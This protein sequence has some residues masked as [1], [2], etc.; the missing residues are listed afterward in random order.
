MHTVA[1]K[2]VLQ[3]YVAL[4]LS[5]IRAGADHNAKTHHNILITNDDSCR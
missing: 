3:L 2:V 5:E 4:C 1:T